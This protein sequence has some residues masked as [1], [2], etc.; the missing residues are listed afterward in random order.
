MFPRTL[1]ARW[2]ARCARRRAMSWLLRQ[3]GDRLIDEIG[4]TREEL[5]QL[6]NAPDGVS[7]REPS[8][9]SFDL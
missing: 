5:R 8:G 4:L 1:M 7:D 2:L 3:P 9:A 6:L